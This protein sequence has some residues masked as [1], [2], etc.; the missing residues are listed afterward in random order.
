MKREVTVKKALRTG[1]FFLVVLP[2]MVFIA[3]LIFGSFVVSKKDRSDVWAIA[4]LP[5]AFLFAWL[6]RS[7][8]ATPWRIWAFTNVRNV[9]E[10]K[11][12]AVSDK[13]ILSTRNFFSKTQV[14][15]R[16]QKRKLLELERKFE[17]ADVFQDDTSIPPQTVIYFSKKHN[18]KECCFGLLLAGTG[19]YWVFAKEQYWMAVFFLIG[20]YMAIL[21]YRK[22]RNRKPQL[23]LS[24]TG[25]H[26]GDGPFLP[27]KIITKIDVS[28]NL[29]VYTLSG[30]S[31]H[32]ID[33]SELDMRT[34]RIKKCI[35]IYIARYEHFEKAYRNS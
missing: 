27:W 32:V 14:A 18:L 29:L 31:H 25:I 2:M 30:L 3:I 20:D 5:C 15:T 23:L 11:S 4:L 33:L 19:L 28:Q 24:E 6:S 35:R 17:V 21:S 7:L 8:A 26:Y 9:H 22:M 13:L 10:L 34:S 1:K 12:R 16:N